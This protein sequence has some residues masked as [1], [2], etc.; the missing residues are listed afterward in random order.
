MRFSDLCLN[1]SFWS[2][3]REWLG[4]G[5]KSRGLIQEAFTFVKVKDDYGWTRSVTLRKEV[6]KSIFCLESSWNILIRH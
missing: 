4:V 1:R 2:L 5:S 3:Y 6:E